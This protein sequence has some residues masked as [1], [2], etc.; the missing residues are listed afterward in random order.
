MHRKALAPCLYLEL[1]DRAAGRRFISRQAY[2]GHSKTTG[3]RS[4]PEA[5]GRVVPASRD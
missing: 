2:G 4:V 1:G 3:D 5:F